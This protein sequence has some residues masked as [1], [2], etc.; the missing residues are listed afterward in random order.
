VLPAQKLYVG[1]IKQVKRIASSIAQALNITGPFSIQL[2]A[3]ANDVKVIECNLRASRTF[4]F[5]SKTFDLNFINLATKAMI[6]LPVKSVPIALIDI[7]YV[8][9]K[10][11]QFSFT[12]L[13]G[14][15]PSLGVEMASTGEVAC[16]GTDMHEAY[17]KALL[18]AGFK[19][20]K[21]K[22]V[23][24]SIGN[25]DIKRE[26]LEGALILQEMGYTIY[27]TPGTHEYLAAQGVKSIALRKPSDPESDLPSVIE[28][29]S[30]GKIELVINVP[31]GTNREELTSGY[32]IRRAAVDFGVSL[33]NNIKCALLFAQAMQKVKKLEICNISEYYAMPT[34]GWRPGQKLTARK[35]SIF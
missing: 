13:H 29:I 11:P 2:M 27:A 8:G 34:I 5:I 17:L 30:T 10:A 32:Q 3:R 31:E 33:I 16:F 6:G 18:S 23:L 20:P 19:M 21:E 1:T 24:V 14:A 35:M 15:D 12:R 4:P 9:V 7:D 28:Y 25:H 22:K 26:F